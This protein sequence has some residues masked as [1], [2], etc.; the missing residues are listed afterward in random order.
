SNPKMGLEETL[1]PTPLPQERT[2]RTSN[3]PCALEPANGPLTPSLS[4]SAGERVPEGR[5]RR[6]FMGR[7]HL[8]NPDA[9]RGHEPTPSPSGGGEQMSGTLAEFP[10]WRGQGWV[11]SWAAGK[12]APVPEFSRPLVWNCFM[13]THVGGYFVWLNKNS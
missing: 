9:N 5:E 1:T 6:R 11:G 2:P 3:A 13:G 10:S 7:E 12:H 8:Q 4:P